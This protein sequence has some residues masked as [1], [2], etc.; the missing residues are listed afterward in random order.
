GGGARGAPSGDHATAVTTSSWPVSVS[1]RSPDAASNRYIRASAPPAASSLPPGCQ[2]RPL[3]ADG[4][5]RFRTST[6]P[7]AASYTDTVPSAPD[8][9]TRVPSGD[10]RAFQIIRCPESVQRGVR[11]TSAGCW[12]NQL[13]CCSYDTCANVS[14]VPSLHRSRSGSKSQTSTRPLRSP[15]TSARPSGDQSTEKKFPAPASYQSATTCHALRPGVACQMRTVRSRL[16]PASQRRS[17]EKAS[18][19]IQPSICPSCLRPPSA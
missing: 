10:Q 11:V 5:G 19:V 16:A 2:A 12:L 17:G 14:I 4:P 6:L 13:A 3:N 7:E 18:D 8:A 1:T 9:A 15:V